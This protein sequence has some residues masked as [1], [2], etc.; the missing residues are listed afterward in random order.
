[1]KLD[2][3]ERAESRG[4]SPVLLNGAPQVSDHSDAHRNAYKYCYSSTSIRRFYIFA[5]PSSKAVPSRFHFKKQNPL[6]L[7]LV[8][9][10]LIL[11]NPLKFFISVL[12]KQL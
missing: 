12:I 3:T 9:L 4:A 1:M 6:S 7:N 5:D 8:M 10:L 2:P 11:L